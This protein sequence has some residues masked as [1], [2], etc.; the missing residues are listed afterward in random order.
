MP[1]RKRTLA[2]MG[3]CE[4]SGSPA[5]SYVRLMNK[6]SPVLFLTKP[7]AVNN[8]DGLRSLS[9]RVNDTVDRKQECLKIA[10]Q[11]TRLECVPACS[12]QMPG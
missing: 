5:I 3:S 11:I 9:S 7:A 8:R 2:R 6:A 12:S 4:F 10:V 1:I